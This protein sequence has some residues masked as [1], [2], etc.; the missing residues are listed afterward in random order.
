MAAVFSAKPGY[1]PS[2]Q[3]QPSIG[4]QDRWRQVVRDTH[5]ESKPNNSYDN[6]ADYYRPTQQPPTK[7]VQTKTSNTDLSVNRSRPRPQDSGRGTSPTKKNFSSRAEYQRGSSRQET[8]NNLEQSQT[9]YSG[10]ESGNGHFQG[11]FL[12]SRGERYSNIATEAWDT[13]EHGNDLQSARVLSANGWNDESALTDDDDD[14]TENSR[15]IHRDKLAMIEIREMQEAGIPIP[16]ERLMSL[17]SNWNVPQQHQL[18]TENEDHHRQHHQSY[19]MQNSPDRSSPESAVFHSV[20]QS[21]EQHQLASLGTIGSHEAVEDEDE[22]E[23]FNPDPR[24]PEEIAADLRDRGFS[25]SSTGRLGSS[26]IPLS[27][28]SPLPVPHEHIARNA[29]LPRSRATSGN[30]GNI[31]DDS[32]SLNK[33]R[34]RSRSVG[35]QL[36]L[37]DPSNLDSSSNGHTSLSTAAK[38]TP[39]GRPLSSHQYLNSTP[40][41]SNNRSVSAQTSSTNMANRRISNSSGIKPRTTSSSFASKAHASPS[42]SARPTTRSGRPNTAVN[43]P[44]GEAPWIATMFKPDPML[45]PDKQILPTHAKRLAQERWE[46]EGKPGNEFEKQVQPINIAANGVYTIGG[47]NGSPTSNTTSIDEA[48]I[49]GGSNWPLAPPTVRMPSGSKFDSNVPNGVP[50][51]PIKSSGASTTESHAGYTTMPKMQS[52]PS[53]PRV[54]AGLPG[55]GMELG[56]LNNKNAGKSDGAAPTKSEKTQE[57]LEKEKACG[58]CLVM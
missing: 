3:N 23:S 24:S 31:E 36:A 51:S 7:R 16:P 48:N 25:V 19:D 15:W 49:M 26:R 54:I 41:T 9:G 17:K 27:K 39:N 1:V 52:T 29:P 42:P 44:E 35:S 22:G 46:R 47:S 57:V 11:R 32:P 53:S 13:N 8:G 18:H 55:G 10:V 2:S 21:P 20:P 30:W 38:S 43:R 12:E 56:D 33:F 5:T 45:P 6:S 28:S 34:R 50:A 40:A 4:E 37:D 58:C 14:V